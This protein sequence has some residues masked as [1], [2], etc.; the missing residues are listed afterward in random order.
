MHPVSPAFP[1]LSQWMLRASVLEIPLCS[2]CALILLA[3]FG[4]DG[5]SGTSSPG[6]Y[7][8]ANLH[9]QDTR[10]SC[11]DLCQSDNLN[12]GSGKTGMHTLYSLLSEGLSLLWCHGPMST[13]GQGWQEGP[14]ILQNPFLD[15]PWVFLCCVVYG[16]DGV[17]TFQ[18]NQS[19]LCNYRLCS[20]TVQLPSLL[21]HY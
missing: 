3:F 6:V 5:F 19:L 15:W 13:D 11:S 18:R 16:K 7:L 1:A 4:S 12:S 9:V 2:L 8:L 20:W 17:H 21:G 10:P 14:P